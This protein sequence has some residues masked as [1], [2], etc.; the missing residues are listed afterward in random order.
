MRSYGK[1][2][3]FSEEP[4]SPAVDEMVKY[5]GEKVVADGATLHGA[6]IIGVKSEAHWRL[7]CE[8]LDP[9]CHIFLKWTTDEP[10]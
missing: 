7:D 4:D 8:S 9:H 5:L 1:E 3:V 10:A 2:W 6:M